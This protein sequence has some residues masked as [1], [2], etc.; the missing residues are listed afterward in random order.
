[1]KTRLICS[2]YAKNWFAGTAIRAM[3]AFA[4]EFRQELRRGLAG[5]T[6]ACEAC[7]AKGFALLVLLHSIISQFSQV[8]K[9]A[10]RYIVACISQL[11]QIGQKGA[12]D[13]V[14][15]VRILLIF[16]NS[17]QTVILWSQQDNKPQSPNHC[18]SSGSHLSAAPLAHVASYLLHMRSW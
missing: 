1:M 2:K 17:H 10:C 3:E 11:Q 8:H 4:S 14:K 9:N 18:G 5:P 12:S 7:C 13:F 6:S 15:L 16:V